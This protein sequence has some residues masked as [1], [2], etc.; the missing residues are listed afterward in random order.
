MQVV[1]VVNYGP[2]FNSTGGLVGYGH[3]VGATGVRQ[4]VDLWEQLKHSEDS[5]GLM[6]NM[7]GD[8]VTC[9]AIMVQ[10]VI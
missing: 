5:L 3:P 10:S 4:L 9:A 2:R 6:L 1:F 7:G 8:D